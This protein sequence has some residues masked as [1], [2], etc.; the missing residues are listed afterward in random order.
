MG[1]LR[2]VAVAGAGLSRFDIYDGRKGRSFKECDE[3]GTEAIL[4]ALEEA[5]MSL[6]DIQ[7]AFCG[8]VYASTAT[9]H[10]AI[11]RIGM[12]GMPIINLE[13]ACSSGGSG[14]RLAYEA[15]AREQYDVV[16]AFG[17]EE[18][19]RGGM[20]KS[21]SWPLYQRQ[22]GFNVQPAS[23]AMGAVRYMEETGATE[24]DFSRVTVKNRRNGALN[25]YA[26]FQK[27][28]TLEEVMASRMVAKPLR[29]LHSCPLADGAA[30]VILCATHKLKSREN[31]VTVAAAV[32]TTGTYG[33]EYGGGSVKIKT[34][35]QITLCMEQAWRMSGL[36][37]GDIDVLQAYDTM[38]AGELWDIEKMGFC[39]K[40]E[41][42]GLLR[43]GHFDIGGKLPV[44]TDGGLL[45]RGHALGATGVA[46]IIEIY[47]QLRGQA[48]KRQVAGAKTGLAHAMGAG[49][50]SSVV[51]L[52]K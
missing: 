13:N 30:A 9:G 33:H 23:Y 4:A 52:K 17:A 28:V 39:G 25:P 12:T 24:E 38:S 5:G 10:N 19:P 29:L 14:F 41:A 47:R 46:Q 31:K 11:K 49:P 34:P 35:H 7:A 2:E 36:G 32:L 22:M 6:T 8:K 44:N 51:I 3:L 48:G 20:I 43:D 45:S 27:P 50:N 42:P 37:P 1:K 18:A 21:T 40:G 16:L 15:I 26:R